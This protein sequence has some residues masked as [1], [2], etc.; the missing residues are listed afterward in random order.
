PTGTG[1]L[2]GKRELL[3]RMP[4]FMGGGDMIKSVSFEK[5]VYDGLPNNVEAG[6]PPPAGAVGLGAAIDY[7]TS[8]GFEDFG[9]H[10]AE[11]LRYATEKLSAVPGLRIIGT[12]KK[13][14]GVISFV[15]YDPPSAGLD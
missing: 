13:K 9:P 14:A 7:V 1:V 3:E 10:E 8:I 2:Y 4:P 5:T 6:T 15:V 11:L 12:A